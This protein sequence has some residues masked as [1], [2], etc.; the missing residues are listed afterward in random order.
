MQNRYFESM[1]FDAFSAAF[2]VY[3]E[4]MKSDGN[5]VSMKTKSDGFESSIRI[6]PSFDR[7]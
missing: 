5:F 4:S 7:L 2:V 1:E 3:F 6:D